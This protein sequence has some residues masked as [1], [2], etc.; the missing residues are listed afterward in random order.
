MDQR[1]KFTI[2]DLA[3]KCRSKAELY[4]M[5]IREGNI[6]L[7]LKQDSTQK[8]LREIMMAKKNYTKCQNITAIKVK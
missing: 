1:D 8:F 4:S 7:P 2:V 3:V 6:Y 5:L